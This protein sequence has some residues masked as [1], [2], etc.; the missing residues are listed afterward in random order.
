MLTDA[1]IQS[2]IN[3]P[4]EITQKVPAKGYK[5][6]NGNQRCNLTL[7]KI[8][9]EGSFSVFI[10]QNSQ[11]I[12]NY[13]IGLCYK[14]QDTDLGS[15]TLI[16]YNGPHG[17]TSRHTDSHY[18]K[19]HVHRIT[20]EEMASGSNQ[21]QERHREITDKY[22]TFEE[23]LYV[24]FSEMCITNWSKYFSELEQRGLFNGRR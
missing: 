9:A 21:P 13:S 12:E 8:G 22:N 10:R 4:K 2:L 19:P 14:T 11:F 7:K 6:E 16:R 20:A 23:A 17:E 3:F 1:E 5:Q 18:N 15:V 24:S